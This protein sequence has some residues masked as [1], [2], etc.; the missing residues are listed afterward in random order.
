MDRWNN[1]VH[2]YRMSQDVTLTT[3]YIYTGCPIDSS[4]SG[5][6]SKPLFEQG[7]KKRVFF[8]LK[9]AFFIVSAA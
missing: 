3:E 9:T 5:E 2:F 7:G 1:I 8:Y 4:N 6:P